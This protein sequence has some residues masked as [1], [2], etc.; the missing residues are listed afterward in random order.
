VCVGNSTAKE[1]VYKTVVVRL[2]SQR[3][4]ALALAQAVPVLP[5]ALTPPA[6]LNI[7]SLDVNLVGQDNSLDY[8]SIDSAA[9]MT[10]A[11]LSM[12]V[13]ASSIVAGHVAAPSLMVMTL[14]CPAAFGN[15]DD[16][17]IAAAMN[18]SS[19]LTT[20]F[21]LLFMGTCADAVASLGLY[22][23]PFTNTLIY[24]AAL[25]KELPRVPNVPGVS[26]HLR[27]CSCLGLAFTLGTA[28]AKG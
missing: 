4:V 18:T 23:K 25:P 24:F 13:D 7:F 2:S 5:L 28:R 11:F 26:I 1:T 19:E 9:L 21:T 14:A 3:A 12:W 22:H 16:P 17:T 15:W 27:F 8:V 20:R 10:G 6:L